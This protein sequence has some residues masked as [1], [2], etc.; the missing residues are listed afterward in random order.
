MLAH[1]LIKP[2]LGEL[3][4]GPVE[5]EDLIDVRVEG[6]RSGTWTSCGRLPRESSSHAD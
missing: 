4:V 2:V 5:Q 6:F 1:P 3:R